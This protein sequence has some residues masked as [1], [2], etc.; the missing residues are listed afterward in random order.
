MAIPDHPSVQKEK[1]LAFAL[2]L[3]LAIVTLAVYWQVQ[4]HDFLV[5]DDFEYVVENPHVRYGLSL[6]K[7]IWAFTA[8]HA[9]NWHPLT[10][11]SHM[12]DCHLYGLNPAGHHLNNL[13]LHLVNTALFLFLLVRMTS[14]PW[15]SA[16]VAAIFALHPLHVETVAWVSERKDLLSTLF[17]FLACHAYVRYTRRPGAGTYAICLLL[18]A[19][20]LM[21]KPMLVTLPFLLLLLDYWPLSRFSISGWRNDLSSLVREKWPFFLLAV[22]S[23]VVTFLVSRSDQAVA[24]TAALPLVIRIGNAILS[25]GLYLIRSLW[26]HDLAFF[27]PH[28]L[29]TTSLW[30][31]A[32]SA[33][34]LVAIS[35]MTL[36]NVRKRPYLITGWLWFLI[37]LLP[38]IGLIQVGSQGLANRYTYVPLIGIAVMVAWGGVKKGGRRKAEGGKQNEREEGQDQQRSRILKAAFAV[39]AVV[40]IL[41]LALITTSEIGYWKNGETLFQRAIAVTSGNYTAHYML[42][43]E[44]MRQG[45]TDEAI[46]HYEE[47]LRFRPDH[48]LARHNLG[49]ALASQ[50][51][52]DEALSHLFAALKLQPGNAGLHA[53]VGDVY[54]MRGELDKAIASYTEALRIDPSLWQVHNNLGVAL[55]RAERASEAKAH[56]EEALKIN[57][58]DRKARAS[59][60]LARKKLE[61]TP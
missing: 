4:G 56:F 3:C 47:A 37:T 29:G 52:T 59:L 15:Q 35:I 32:G 41:L 5:W 42:G 13:I 7:V 1:T 10:W 21:S 40:V 50:G 8:P 16:F 45:R 19:L 49:T 24:S 22:L 55:L 54:L 9:S 33:L 2:A 36:R 44:R 46:H 38:V 51:K 31:I 61:G 14:K 6:E 48:L 34:L 26:P 53:S 60:E 30:E 57:P 20:G 17:L 28:P 43:I 39:C 18:F 58:D 23:S 27:Y 11:I 12:L 25:Y